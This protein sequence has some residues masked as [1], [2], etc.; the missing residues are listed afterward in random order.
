MPV[1]DDGVKDISRPIYKLEVEL[2]NSNS[3]GEWKAGNEI[4]KEPTNMTMTFNYVSDKDEDGKYDFNF[5]VNGDIQTAFYKAYAEIDGEVKPVLLRSSDASREN[6]EI[7]IYEGFFNDNAKSADSIL[8]QV[9][10]IFKAGTVL[11]PV[12][13]STYTVNPDMGGYILE[14][15]VTVTYDN[16]TWK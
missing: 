14:Q 11:T 9:T 8:P 2:Y 4:S 6:Q 7:W 16:G 5:K 13:D 15:D 3:T 10:L 1:N 12:T